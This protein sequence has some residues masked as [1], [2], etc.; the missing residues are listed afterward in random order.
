MCGIVGYI[1]D[2]APKSILYSGMAKLEYRGYDSAGVA[3]LEDGEIKVR[4]EVGKLCVLGEELAKEKIGGNIGIGHTRWATHGKPTVANAHPHL[5]C[6]GEIVL[7]H[8]GI[9]E[10]YRELKE[11]LT[12]KG[13]KFLSET[14]TEAI[15]HLIEEYYTG[16]LFAAVGKAA[17]YLEGAYAIAVYTKKEPDKIVVAR[18]GSPLVIGLGVGENLIASDIP[19]VLE[20]TKNVIFL[21]DGEM[22]IVEKD[23]VTITDMEGNKKEKAVK[24]I[25][26]TVEMAEKNGY[27]HFMLKEIYEQPRVVEDTLRG[28][29]TE[30]S[31]NL[32]EMKLSDAE[33]KGVEKI[34]IVACGTSYH[35]GLV[36]KYILEKKLRIP[37]EVDVASEFRYKD[38]IVNNKN[39][40]ILISQSGE[41][42]DTLAALREAK[43]KG[44]KV[45][46]IIN[47][48]G[49]TITRESD[50]TIYT[51]AGP[52]M[53]VAS[54]KAF[55]SQLI[56]LYLLM[57][58]LGEK[59]EV[60]SV[61]ERKE[62][63]DNLKTIP[64][65]IDEVLKRDGEILKA[66]EEFKDVHSLMYIGRNLNYPIALEGALK[67]KE[68][69]YI[70]AEG[71]PA[72]ELKHGPIALIEE[73]VPTVAIAV[74]G[75]TYDKMI[76]NIQEIKAR[77]GKIIAVAT[78]GDHKINDFAD[79]VLR[80]HEVD[81]LYSPIL[82]VLPL[83]L[84][85]YHIADK[86]GLDV[87][88]PRNLAKSVTVE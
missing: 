33:L 39:L 88:K 13:H 53:G 37:V 11:E 87:D 56:A 35:A 41:T 75:E 70:H 62:I 68:I 72:G 77:S 57:V 3:I 52:E 6:K 15:V 19:A 23:K 31:V 45:I 28:K 21:D 20:Y 25:D 30:T 64:E 83:Q 29:I 73:K 18:K 81:E 84:L 8:N 14:D 79:V 1:G 43:K 16:N 42:A 82:T 49:S 17:K 47:V 66:S 46:G 80:V 4:R 69:S 78:D 60:L 44:A 50:G 38:P 10:N 34:N 67:L 22:A 85:G 61:Q 58:Y 48:V 26:W 36:G 63:I 7:V 74:K 32:E 51:N 65:M 5:D 55:V 86:R 9:I 12:K 2:K 27:K 76:S 24:V 59:R 54:T 71:Y 40:V